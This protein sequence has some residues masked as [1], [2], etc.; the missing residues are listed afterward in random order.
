M[1]LGM[2]PFQ[3]SPRTPGSLGI[4]D[5]AAPFGPS[6][7]FGDTPGSLGVND[8]AASIAQGVQSRPNAVSSQLQGWTPPP[9][10]DAITAAFQLSQKLGWTDY[11]LKAA[12]ERSLDPEVLMA[13]GYRE[14]GL[15]EKYLKVPGDNGN[16]YGLMQIDI[17]AYPTWVNSGKWK[18][19][20]AC[21]SKGA[22][23]LAAKRDEITASSGD[24]DIKVKT[25]AGV[26]YKFDGKPIAGDDLLRVSIA[27][28]NCGMWAYYHYSKGHDVDQGTTDQNYSKDVLLKSQRFKDLLN[29]SQDS[30]GWMDLPSARNIA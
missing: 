17:R 21:I 23:V 9:P 22:E 19:A 10:A 25:L 11:F 5:A 28:Y 6:G 27:A 7:L 30:R 26:T 2:D 16:G 14:S 18:D 8:H 1:L 29:P 24:K 20:E 12:T 13:I 3:L 15:K 4:K